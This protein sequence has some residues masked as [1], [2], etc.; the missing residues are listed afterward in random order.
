MMKKAASSFKGG[1]VVSRSR[2]PEP[3]QSRPVLSVVILRRVADPFVQR[4]FIFTVSDGSISEFIQSL[5][6]QSRKCVFSGRWRADTGLASSSFGNLERI[7]AAHWAWVGRP[8]RDAGKS[9]RT[10]GSLGAY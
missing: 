9:T 7:A 1:G 8:G 3:S 5:L 6:H 2:A 10:K 4:T